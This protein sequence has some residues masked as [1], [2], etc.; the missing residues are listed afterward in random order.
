MGQP[1]K[2]LSGKTFNFIQVDS[3]IKRENN[4]K[5]LSLGEIAERLNVNYKTLW[6]QL[7]RDKIN[8]YNLIEI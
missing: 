6:Q 2:D 5:K 8:K 1:I 4:G 7:T 3:F